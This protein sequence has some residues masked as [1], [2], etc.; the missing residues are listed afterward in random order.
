MKNIIYTAGFLLMTNT[1]IADEQ[2]DIV[3]QW[4]GTNFELI[5]E[6]HNETLFFNKYITTDNGSC[7]LNV[8]ASLVSGERNTT[9]NCDGNGYGM[10]IE[11]FG[12]G[13]KTGLVKI[14]TKDSDGRRCGLQWD[15]HPGDDQF[16]NAPINYDQHQAKWDC[17][18]DRDPSSADVV[19]LDDVHIYNGSL[20]FKIKSKVG[21]LSDD[22][23]QSNHRNAVWTKRKSDANTISIDLG[24]YWA[25]EKNSN[26]V[27]MYG[28]KP[29]EIIKQQ[30]LKDYEDAEKQ[31]LKVLDA[32]LN[33]P[34]H[35]EHTTNLTVWND[36]NSPENGYITAVHYM[37]YFFIGGHKI[38]FMSNKKVTNKRESH[39]RRFSAWYT[40]GGLLSNALG[41]ALY[42]SRQATGP[43]VYKELNLEKADTIYYGHESY[44]YSSN[45]YGMPHFD[46]HWVSASI[47][48]NDD[49]RYVFTSLGDYYRLQTDGWGLE[50][51]N[52]RFKV[53]N[54]NWP[55][56]E[57][58][59][60]LIRAGL[61]SADGDYWYFFLADGTYIKYSI[62]N[63]YVLDGYPAPVNNSRWTDMEQ[64]KFQ[65][66]GAFYYAGDYYF[67]LR[68][69]SYILYDSDDSGIE[70][71]KLDDFDTGYWGERSLY[72][73]EQCDQP[74]PNISL[75]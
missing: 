2:T 31:Y 14:W 23:S 18:G 65:I 59:R 8:E 75:F 67:M 57:D 50:Y 72:K 13:N 30:S 39:G 21:Y 45:T 4:I 33:E 61:S 63:D 3:K 47:N 43:H 48:K 71:K 16:G 53:N 54:H 10:H 28:F 55:G 74:K 58:Y 42:R 46:D 5:N 20:Q 26:L 73:L 41:Q 25:D 64:Y 1:V 66:T 6:L 32:Y 38:N 51:I 62:A 12:D 36:K 68:D 44:N 60:F 11:S 19:Y 24:W 29:P 17:D 37:D 49:V 40:N 35:A 22:N 52:N 9:W 7:K 27:D 15:A 70:N 56:L 69:G 34:G